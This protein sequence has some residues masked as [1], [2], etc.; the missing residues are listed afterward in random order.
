[1]KGGKTMFE[2]FVPLVLPAEVD[3]ISIARANVRGILDS[4]HGD[5]DFMIEMLQNAVDAL[6]L[7]FNSSCKQSDEKPEIEIV[8]N[9][10]AGTV[11]VSDNGI[12][13]NTD[14]AK[15]ILYPNYTNKPYSRTEAGKRSL[16]GHKGVGLTFLAFGFNLLR[17]C[18]KKDNDFFSGEISGGKLW[19]DT[20]EEAELPKV[21]P[22]EYCP[23]FLEGRKSGSSFEVAIG[24]EFSQRVSMNW[25]GWHYVTR[26]MTAAGYCDI[27]ELFPWNKNAIVTLRVIDKNGV[28]E[29]PP[30]GYSEQLPLEYFYP[31]NVLKSCNLDKYFAKYSDR[32][33]PPKSERGKYEAL[34]IKWDTDRIE[35]VIFHKGEID[36]AQSARYAHYQFTKQHLP[37]IY[38][39]FTHSQR[40]WR[41][42]L[43]EGYSSDKRRRFW[44]PG[45]QVVTQQMPTGQ[46]QE[47]S[48]PFRAGN[49]DRFFMLVDMPDAKPD[50]GRKGFKADINSY[51]QFIASELILDYFLRNRVL[52]KPTS[53]AH[54]PTI[55]DA[56]AA[57]DQ[58]I[59]QV[60]ELP[61]LGVPALNFKKEPQYEND[62]IALFSELLS[63]DHIRGFE[64]LS[65]SSGSQYDGVV[66]YRFTRNTE[67]LLYHPTSNPLGVTKTHIAKTDLLSKN[68][69]F[70]KSLIHLIDDFDEET[71]SPQ[72]V[73]FV[74]TWDEGD[75]T[76]SG[77]EIIDLLEGDNYELRSFHGETHQLVLEGAT[78]PVI[79]LKYV[80]KL[81]FAK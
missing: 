35:S 36:D 8:I 41:E 27:N 69:E 78:I 62:V 70:K 42:R 44:R 79:M 31:D 72:K 34:F 45:I 46:I 53:I 6:D 61:E 9:Q 33:E 2:P 39:M 52:L 13:M 21:N 15:L 59:L 64:I 28:K 5:W 11:R 38:A 57:A 65:V 47:V 81:L 77:Y 56:E 12:G 40:I 48:L 22:S 74:V 4:Y 25:L 60:Q 3:A 26:C 54:G 18:S 51:V 7:K 43:D 24:P 66:N 30:D 32:T 23:E 76:G 55:V 80:I 58:R 19:V 63:R 68:L 49:R 1:V 50:Y 71:K 37:T 67:K 17:Y 73:R 29:T 16:R 20:E 14:E 10:K 75:T